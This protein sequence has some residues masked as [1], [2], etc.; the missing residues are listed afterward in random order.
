MA[1]QFFQ[2]K[3]SPEVFSGTQGRSGLVAKG[4]SFGSE[5]AFIAAGGIKGA[6]GQPYW[7]NVTSIT[8]GQ[9][10]AEHTLNVPPVTPITPGQLTPT[11]KLDISGQQRLDGTEADL[12]NAGGVEFSKQID[13][14]VAEQ[15]KREEAKT[16]DIAGLLTGLEEEPAEKLKLQEEA[17]LTEMA[18]QQ[19]VVRG[20][21]DVLNAQFIE[22]QNQYDLQIKALRE[23]PGMLLPHFAGARA[24]EQERLALKKNTLASQILLKQA[25]SLALSRR[26]TAAQDSVNRAIDIKYETIRLKL[27]TELF[28]LDAIRGDL[29]KSEQKQ[30]NLR[31]EEVARQQDAL[32]ER[33]SREVAVENVA[34]QAAAALAPPEVVDQ[35]K[36]L[37]ESGDVVQAMQIVAPYLAPEEVI[38][39]APVYAPTSAM[40]EYNLARSQ[41]FTGT[42]QEWQDRGVEPSIEPPI[43]EIGYT[44]SELKKLRNTGIDPSDIELADT[45][46]YSG[47]VE[48]EILKKQREKGEGTT[49]FIGDVF[50]K[51]WS[52]VTNFLGF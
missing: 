42:F 33:K 36:A 30:W 31:Q 43:E 23:Q 24:R 12:I 37:A 52:G 29:T 34:I 22:L 51:M 5:E 50:S 41:G 20:D 8:Q 6:E 35:I 2:I 44:N 38:P 45:F 3:G 19:A 16:E 4:E 27:D 49:G 14:Q 26:Q 13:K 7:Q 21:I 1:N 18:Q 32:E 40:K 39:T 15:Q 17:G 47:E 28:L 9:L 48:A 11:T 10:V 25:E 46:L